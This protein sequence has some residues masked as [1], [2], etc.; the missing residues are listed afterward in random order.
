MCCRGQR[1]KRR[2]RLGRKSSKRPGSNKQ[3]TWIRSSAHFGAQ[4][5]LVVKGNGP[6]QLA[7]AGHAAICVG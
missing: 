2:P 3:A 7:I 5:A 4:E 6:D 1:L